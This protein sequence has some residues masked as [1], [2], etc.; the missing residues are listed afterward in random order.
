MHPLVLDRSSHL[1]DRAPFTAAHREA[2]RVARSALRALDL[3]APSRPA[4]WRYRD[5][6]TL[7]DRLDADDGRRR[8][9]PATGTRPELVAA[10]HAALQRLA[11]LGAPADDVA[12]VVAALRAAVAGEAEARDAR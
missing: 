1:P 3:G 11:D 2:H 9:E 8:V 12:V 7:L 4:G 10:A 5:V 6:V